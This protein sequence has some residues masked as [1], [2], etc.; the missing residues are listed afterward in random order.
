MPTI[1]KVKEKSISWWIKRCDKAFSLLVRSVGSCQYCGTGENLQTAHIV[2]RSNK[3]LRW[4]PINAVCLCT[5]CHIF[6]FHHSPLEFVE[7][8]E[9]RYPERMVYIRANRNKITNRTVDDYRI[10]LEA[11]ETRNIS[12]LTK[13]TP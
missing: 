9:S 13:I 1:K 2:G 8:L 12:Y 11:I 10:L 4:N 6:K 3:T 5:R 7:W